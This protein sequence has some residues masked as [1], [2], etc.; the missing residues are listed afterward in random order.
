MKRS[1][2]VNALAEVASQGKYTVDPAGARNMNAVFT[3]VAELLN[4]LE[5]EEA[6][7]EE[8]TDDS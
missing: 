5:A 3:V 7:E 1:Q 4:E 2:I 6:A 8:N